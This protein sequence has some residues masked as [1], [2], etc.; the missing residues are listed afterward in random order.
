MIQRIQTLY[1]L[2]AAVFVGLMFA[3][4]IATFSAGGSEMALTAFSVTDTTTPEAPVTVYNTLY[5]GILLAV[6][7]LVP[8]I[9]IFLFK[10]RLLQFRLC[11]A[12]IVLLLGS[13]GFEIYYI[14]FVKST[15]DAV[16]WKIGIS[17]S[18]PLVALIFVILA[19]R[20]IA[21][22]ERLVRSLDRIR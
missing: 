16:I 3:M 5:L 14:S 19:L 11:F 8:F 15:I 21:R 6:A 2:L 22:D 10:R 9:T 4:P 20:A 7:A 12:E 17:A 1:L 18:F 13:I